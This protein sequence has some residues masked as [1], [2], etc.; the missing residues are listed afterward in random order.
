MIETSVNLL[1]VPFLW[2]RSGYRLTRTLSTQKS[3]TLLS[4]APHT[5]SVVPLGPRPPPR[6]LPGTTSPLSSTV[7]WLWRCILTV[8]SHLPPLLR[9]ELESIY[10]RIFGNLLYLPSDHLIAAAILEFAAV[11][12]VAYLI[13]LILFSPIKVISIYLYLPYPDHT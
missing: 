2:T 1:F 4:F 9:L 6:S 11:C 10:R 7:L 3:S 12:A 13:G 8:W 5:L